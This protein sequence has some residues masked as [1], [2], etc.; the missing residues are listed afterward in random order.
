[1]SRSKFKRR[2]FAIHSSCSPCGPR[3][4]GASNQPAPTTVRRHCLV[5]ATGPPPEHYPRDTGG[6]EQTCSLSCESEGLKLKRWDVTKMH[7]HCAGCVGGV[8]GA[9][10][11][12]SL[13]VPATV[14]VC[15]NSNPRSFLCLGGPPWV[16][17]R[18]LQKGLPALLIFQPSILTIQKL[19]RPRGPCAIISGGGR[20]LGHASHCFVT[21]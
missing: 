9:C 21:A 13:G 4:N 20:A 16:V 17:T 7:C 3:C 8:S 5:R 6:F 15:E 2:L 1:M 19:E 12:P 14:P 11:I 18:R 10:Q